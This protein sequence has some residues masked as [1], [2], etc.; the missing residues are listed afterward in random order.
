M[1]TWVLYDIANDR[2]RTKVAKLCKKA[3][4]YRVQ[5]SVFLGKLGANEKDALALELESL[6]DARCDKVYVFRM[7]Q[8]ELKQCVLL[9]QAFDRALVNDEVSAL[10]F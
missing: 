8:P 9:G 1:I 7:T 4:L 6:I 10:F 2:S 3:G 5:L